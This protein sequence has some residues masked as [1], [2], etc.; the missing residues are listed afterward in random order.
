[1]LVISPDVTL[2]IEGELSDERGDLM[3][4]LRTA[5][6]IAPAPSL[7]RVQSSSRCLLHSARER[8]ELNAKV[9]RLKLNA[10]ST[11]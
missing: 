10:V 3:E 9:S 8:K 11:M 5:M 6:Q 1:M 7:L 2:E 4:T